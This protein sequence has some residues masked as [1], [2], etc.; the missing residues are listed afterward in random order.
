M[1]IPIEGGQIVSAVCRALHAA[2]G[3]IPIHRE[4]ID[5]DFGEPCFFVWCSGTQTSPVIW[6]RYR[7]THSIEVRYYPPG[8]DS[9]QGAGLDMGARLIG[10]LARITIKEGEAESLPIFAT[11]YEMQGVDGSLHIGITY[12]TEGY[13]DEGQAAG[14]MGGM[15]A[16][17]IPKE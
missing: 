11:G 4:A 17:V 14:P 15:A 9:M 5:Q 1:R 12:R 8:R 2:F 3:E 7:Q 10:V 16:Q 13:F 6:P